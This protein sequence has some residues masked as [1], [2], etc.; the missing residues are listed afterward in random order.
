MDRTGLK[1]LGNNKNIQSIISVNTNILLRRFRLKFLRIMCSTSCYKERLNFENT[2]ISLRPKAV[3]KDRFFLSYRNKRCT[4]QPVGKNHFGGIPCKVATY[5]DLANPKA[6]TGHC[7]RRTSATLHSDARGCLESLMRLGGW[8]SSS[9]AGTYA[10]NSECSKNMNASIVAGVEKPTPTILK[11]ACI[12][13]PSGSTIDSTAKL[14]SFGCSSCFENCNFY[15]KKVI[16]LSFSLIKV[17]Y[18]K[19]M[20]IFH[21]I[22]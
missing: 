15:F 9:V 4:V 8:K 17:L 6:Y 12:N 1:I 5:L 18:L 21:N 14:G 16:L 13:I 11:E 2:G 10:D 7:L 20:I 19:F 3:P 22:V